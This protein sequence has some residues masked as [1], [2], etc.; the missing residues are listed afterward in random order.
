MV[1]ACKNK[2]DHPGAKRA[3]GN[4]DGKRGENHKTKKKS[5]RQPLTYRHP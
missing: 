1:F 5:A 2:L 3:L 4:N